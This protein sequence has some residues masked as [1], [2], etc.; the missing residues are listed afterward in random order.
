[1]ANGLLKVCLIFACIKQGSVCQRISKVCEFQNSIYSLLRKL[2][3]VKLHLIV[4]VQYMYSQTW[5][6]QK[7]RW[8]LF[9]SEFHLQV[10]GFLFEEVIMTSPYFTFKTITRS[11][12]RTHADI[13]PLDLK[14]NALTTRPPCWY[15][16]YFVICIDLFMV[17]LG[18]I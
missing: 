2:C 4:K 12:V 16:G 10:Y 6:F 1:M 15:S 11:G 18:I 3:F 14:S 8:A 13:R 9:L 7:H 17:D 5:R